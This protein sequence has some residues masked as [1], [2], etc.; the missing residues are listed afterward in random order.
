MRLFFKAVAYSSH[1]FDII[2]ADSQFF[3]QTH[4]LD[5][6]GPIRNRIIFAMHPIDNLC[7]G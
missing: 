5:V 7:S 2:A 4:H 3:P 6:H 1:R